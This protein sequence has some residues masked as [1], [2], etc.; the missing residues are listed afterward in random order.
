[1][2]FAGIKTFRVKILLAAA[3]ISI[4]GYGALVSFMTISREHEARENGMEMAQQIARTEA[5]KASLRLSLAMRLGRDVGHAIVG[6]HEAG[7]Q[8]RQAINRMLEYTLRQ[9]PEVLG[10]YTGWEPNA[11]D[12]KDKEFYG[13]TELGTDAIG[14]FVPYWH[15]TGDKL[16]V[17]P[18]VDYD[19]EGAGD[20]YLLPKRTGKPVLIDP[21]VYT[22][23]GVPT[24]ITS[25]I[26]PLM[27]Q[28]KFIGISGA[29]IALAGF[30][31]EFAKIRPFNVGLLK[32]YSNTGTFIALPDTS[33]VGKT[34]NE[35]ELPLEARQPLLQGKNY[36]YIN[37]TGVGHFLEP[38]WIEGVEKPWI[39]EVEVPIA[40][41]LE[42]VVEARNHSLW[43]GFISL[44][45][46]LTLLLLLV[47]VL[48]RPIRHLRDT[49][50]NLAG[51]SG[52]LKTQINVESEDEIGETAQAFNQFVGKLRRMFLEVR[53]ETGELSK[54]INRLTSMTR[55]IVDETLQHTDIS[56]KNAATVEQITASI[57]HIA[58]SARNADLL[59]RG[60]GERSITGVETVRQASDL[61][62]RVS[63]DMEKL[64]GTMLGLSQRSAEIQSIAGVIKDIS[65]QTNLLALNAAIEA[66]RA[67]DVGRGFAVVADEV[68]KLAE[69]TANA[70][71]Q[72]DEMISG[73]HQETERAV[74]NMQATGGAVNNSVSQSEV[75]A[76][77]IQSMH[78]MLQQVVVMMKEIASATTE[79][80]TAAT[81]MAQ[82]VERAEQMAQSMNESLLD[83]SKTLDNLDQR[84]SGL[85]RL[86]EQFKL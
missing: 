15:Y 8:D 23:S 78:D 49:M 59:A 36:H 67:G 24:L 1:M 85:S 58:D 42:G 48:T 66:A 31:T 72:I 60:A 40:T 43:I 65:D 62:A 81:Q 13:R 82:S 56:S 51:D 57:A 27:Q 61:V 17:E 33:R 12:G 25:L 79:Q 73:V 76:M 50:R 21:Y 55:D 5:Q 7:V 35:K 45:L 75:A 63:G 4:V 44:V 54:G 14:R 6:L 74:C 52:D 19:K 37:S 68:R 3:A 83:A 26:T 77:E 47:N 11:Y 38:V 10:V 39:L 53:D 64:S 41:L 22:I 29:D 9:H 34:A 80:S 86:V 2:Q 71:V 30:Q 70:T 84:A 32:L 18:M 69:R 20:Y 46:M 28:G 16:V